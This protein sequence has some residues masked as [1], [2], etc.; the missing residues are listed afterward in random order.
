MGQSLSEVEHVFVSTEDAE[1]AEVGN[2]F[3]AEVIKRPAE[4]A[5]DT[6]PEWLAWQHAIQLVQARHGIFDR[7]LS[8]PPTAPLRSKVDVQKCLDLLDENTDVVITMTPATRSPWFNMVCEDEFG[9]L[10]LLVEGNFA[11]RQDAPLGYDMTT[12]AYVLRP[13]FINNYQRLWDGR[14]KGIVVPNERALDIDTPLDLEIARFLKA[15]DYIQTSN[16]G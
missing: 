6:S 14:V 9:H 2:A 7:F 16:S 11:R 4:L 10:K 15:K 8:L 13:K 5:Q 12:V 1:I 3:G